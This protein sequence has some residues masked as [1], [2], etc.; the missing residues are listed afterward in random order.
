MN[1]NVSSHRSFFAFIEFLLTKVIEPAK[2]HVIQSNAGTL[3]ESSSRKTKKEQAEEAQLKELENMYMS[4]RL[5]AKQYLD[6][7]AKTHVRCKSNEEDEVASDT[8]SV[9]DPDEEIDNASDWE[10][11]DE[12]WLTSGIKQH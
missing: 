10:D 8:G 12:E 3:P 11:F 1:A 6:E 7:L 5:T 2:L 9:D 4:D